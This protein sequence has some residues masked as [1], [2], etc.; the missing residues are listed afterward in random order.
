MRE[1]ARPI[2]RWRSMTVVRALIGATAGSLLIASLI[3]S[4]LLVEGYRHR[5]AAT[6]EGVIAVVM[7]IGLALTWSPAPWSDRAAVG[8]LGFGLLGTLVGMFTIV[9]GVGPRTAADVVYHI[10]LLAALT[11]GL[12]LAVRAAPGGGAGRR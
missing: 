7:L 9:I 8:A 12:F 4:G 2:G 10:A 6:A 1:E 5:Q 11:A 3:H